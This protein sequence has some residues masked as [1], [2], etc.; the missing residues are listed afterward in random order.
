MTQK[1]SYKQSPKE[2]KEEAVALVTDQGY[3]VPKAAEALGVATNMLYR[4]KENAGI[5]LSEG[6]R[7]EL[8]SLRKEVKTLRVEKDILNKASAF[9][10]KEMK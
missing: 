5:L 3:T 6:E 1:R 4:W 7:T 9:F 2:F 10:A 8:K